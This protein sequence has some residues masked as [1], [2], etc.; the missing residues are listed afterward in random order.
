MKNISEIVL[1]YISTISLI[2]L[3]LLTF[4]NGTIAQAFTKFVYYLIH[5]LVY[6][7]FNQ[8]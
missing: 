8:R 6:L 2:F 4:F 7:S 5:L 3:S 1:E